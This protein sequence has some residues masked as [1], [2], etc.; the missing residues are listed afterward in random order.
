MTKYKILSTGSTVNLTKDNFKA[1][2]G[3][4]SIYIIGDTVYKVCEPGKMIPDAK[5]KELSVLDHPH[6]ISPDDV[7]LDTK[8]KPVGYTMRLVPGD[9]RPLAQILT[10]NYREREGVTPNHSMKLVQQIAE[11][12]RSIHKHDGYL[13]VDGNEFNYMVTNKHDEVYFI[14][15]NSFQTP[16]FPATAIM[17]SIRD[18][19]V[20]KNSS[21]MHVWTKLS[22]WYSFAII[23]F[24]MFTAIH[25]FKGR[26]PAFTNMKTL[27]NDQMQGCKSVLDPQTQYPLGAVYHP[28]E[29]VIPGGKDGAFMQW[30]RAIF[31][32]NKRLE[33]PKD[34]QATLTFITKIKEIIGSNNFNIQEL[35]DLYDTIIGYYEKNGSEV[36]VTRNHIFLN[37]KK[38]NRP[39]ER[40]RV[41]FSPKNNVPY[42]CWIE[43]ENVK[44]QNL[45]DGERITSTIGGSDIMS[46]EGRIY[47]Q[48]LHNIFEIVFIEQS[49]M[50]ATAKTVATIM[51]SA[52]TM[53][54]GVVIQD[55]FGTL[56]FSMFPEQGHHRQIKIHE[57]D[58]YRITDA[59]YENNVLMILGVDKEN[60][61]YNRFVLRFSKD[62]LS[63]DIRQIDVMSPTGINF[64]VI[65]KGLCVCLTE[66][67]KVEIFSNQKDK[68]SINVFDDPAV[69]GEMK[70]CHAGNQV[71]FAR[72]NK[73]FDISVKKGTT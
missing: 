6:I 53:Y 13:Q 8:N 4:G 35:R 43:N 60:G 58:N 52:T 25:P 29:D 64:T 30:Y 37:G 49:T 66:D 31:I 3:E 26:H 71:K 63:Y 21:N 34:F 7:I 27:M 57:L 45:Q 16:H 11:G 14:D 5:L 22:D 44:I 61:K 65:D 62:W 47:V 10:K 73:L 17:P 55:M 41:G 54:Q 40:F 59:K 46:C 42:A 50:V 23:S 20:A 19:H 70:F 15:V 72:G 28:F 9:A 12:L 24:Y 39:A 56:V 38:A 68:P 1:K 18:W 2:G 67:E 51:P 32:D 69:D 36:S 33:A 48:S